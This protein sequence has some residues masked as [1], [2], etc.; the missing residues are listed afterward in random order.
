[1][2][3][4]ANDTR[5]LRGNRSQCGGCGLYFSSVS[6]F[7]K[8]RVAIDKDGNRRCLDEAEMRAKGMDINERGWWVSALLTDEQRQSMNVRWAAQ[9]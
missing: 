3:S 8:H 7:D 9:R 1:M 2:A 4:T 5:T 6:A